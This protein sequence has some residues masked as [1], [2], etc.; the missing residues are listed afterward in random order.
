MARLRIST[1]RPRSGVVC[2]ALSGDLDMSS[3][4]RLDEELRRIEHTGPDTVVVDLRELVF[5]DSAGLSRLLAAHR[6]ARRGRWR[7]GL[8][9]GPAAVERM[10]RMTASGERF[11]TLPDPATAA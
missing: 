6:R 1:H 2:V 8:T 5:M 7:F 9:R 11:L 4:Y 10:L 3:A